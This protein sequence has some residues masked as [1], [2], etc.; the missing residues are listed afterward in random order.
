MPTLRMNIVPWLFGESSVPKESDDGN[1]ALRSSTTWHCCCMVLLLRR[2]NRRQSLETV[3]VASRFVVV[4]GVA[5]ACGMWQPGEGQRG[6][7][8]SVR[9]RF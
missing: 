4:A 3:H 2:C 8:G 7:A 5:S 6:G 1:Q 9:R